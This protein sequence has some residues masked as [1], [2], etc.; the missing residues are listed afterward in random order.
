M[1]EIINDFS[2]IM[3][4]RITQNNF[5]DVVM[6]QTSSIMSATLLLQNKNKTLSGAHCQCTRTCGP[7][8][9][10]ILFQS[11]T[12]YTSKITWGPITSPKFRNTICWASCRSCISPSA[13]HVHK[14]RETTCDMQNQQHFDRTQL[15]FRS[16][17]DTWEKIHD[18]A[19]VCHAMV[20]LY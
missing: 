12:T 11:S 8:H 19:L 20:V 18:C 1:R 17:M 4:P 14:I 7:L 10:R 5:G 13:V 3:G 16:G 6:F 2:G 9:C 15:I